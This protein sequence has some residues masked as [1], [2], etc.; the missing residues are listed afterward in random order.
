MRDA[1]AIP[2]PPPLPSSRPS[3][4]SSLE[5]AVGLAPSTRL[6]PP[7]VVALS[8]WQSWE[9]LRSTASMLAPMTASSQAAKK[10]RALRVWAMVSARGGPPNEPPDISVCASCVASAARELASSTPPPD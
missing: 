6:S 7:V 9:M 5:V 8:A 1:A 2:A 4:S 10:P 3:S